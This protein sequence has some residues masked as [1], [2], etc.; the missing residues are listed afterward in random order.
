[1]ENEKLN[2]VTQAQPVIPAK[3]PEKYKDRLRKM[4]SRQLRGE[5][6]IQ[7][8]KAEKAH[9]PHGVILATVLGIVF[10]TKVEP[11]IR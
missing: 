1:M 11:Y 8:R 6:K 4:S 3:P 7:G 10:D 5:I 2:E 9:Q